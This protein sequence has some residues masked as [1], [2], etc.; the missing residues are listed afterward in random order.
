M[1]SR[2]IRF[3]ITALTLL[4]G[5]VGAKAQDPLELRADSLYRTYNFSRAKSI[6]RNLLPLE[7]SAEARQRLELKSIAC[8]NGEAM[9]QF[10]EEPKVVARQSLSK[11]DFY[12]YYPDITKKG[13]FVEAP[14]NM[15][16]N[17]DTIYVPSAVDILYYSARDT[18]G[19]WSIYVTKKGE[20]DIWSAPQPMGPN[21]TSAG[22]DIF[23]FVS[24]D[25]KRLYF[26]SNGHFGAGGYDLYVCEWD[27]AAGD[28]GMA[29]NMGFPYSSPADDFFYYMTP[30]GT[31]AV[32]S[33][34]RNWDAPGSRASSRDR[35]TAYVVEYE[36]NPLK[37][38][39]TPEEAASIA[40]LRLRTSQDERD[41][42]EKENVN[43]ALDG[44]EKDSEIIKLDSAQL[45]ATENYKRISLNF[46]EL[47]RKNKALAAQIKSNREK[48]AA[49]QRNTGM[50]EATDSLALKIASEIEA[51][52]LS[53]LSLQEEIR[54]V[55]EEMLAAEE[56]F[57]SGG[58]MIPALQE[59]DSAREEKSPD[60]LNNELRNGEGK[61]VE[62][63]AP[64]EL[65]TQKAG[66]GKGD[67]LKVEKPEIAV[68]LSFRTNET[69]GPV[70]LKELPDGIIYQ[71][72][73]FSVVSPVRNF[74]LF[75]GFAPVFE[76][77]SDAGRYQYSVGAFEKYP[78]AAKAL[79]AVKRSFPSALL[80]AYNN[81]KPVT[82]A[83][84][85]KSENA[86]AAKKEAG[87]KSGTAYNV[88]ID[89][90]TSAPAEN[91]MNILRNSGKDIA[92]N[93]VSGVLRY[94]VGPFT[95]SDEAEDLA[96]K[97]KAVSDKSISVETIGGK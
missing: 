77:V 19:K 15:S 90:Y 8:D 13:S 40:R 6:Y 23:P 39:A 80:T 92:R 26:S 49:L 78:D 2:I 58:M 28:W 16:G 33:S 91:V 87:K 69:S 7:N 48:Y 89:G 1:E 22:N 82:V 50:P 59:T 53:M 51:Q 47:Q 11:K 84:A 75:K 95:D 74:A 64:A 72:R 29:Q 54:N 42:A 41:E 83:L 81:G 97:L 20:G 73:I 37:R 66:V 3:G 27:E 60:S 45:A 62:R 68:D 36:T 67:F 63:V 24:P 17:G 38:S 52:E 88:V 86:A 44:L 18:K 5:V 70:D 46:R 10:V 34:T 96:A 30:D 85:R 93:S 94:V 12:L 71:I 76:R 55:S 32:F 56:I 4:A 79:A 57:M 35:V 25:G 14:M 9:L 31:Y 21:I 65:L 61:A 43:R